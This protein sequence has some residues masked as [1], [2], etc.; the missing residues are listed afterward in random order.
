V[1]KY[2]AFN[3]TRQTLVASE[4]EVAET[5]WSRMKG[6]LGRSAKDFC[7]GKGLWIVPSDGIH[8]IG[9]SFPIDVVYLDSKRRVIRTYHRLA[10]FRIAAVKLR[11]RSIL[12]LPPGALAESRT[13][14]GDLLQF[15]VSEE[16]RGVAC[17][18]NT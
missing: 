13:E 8:T 7:N 11:A 5:A 6:L 12:E 4:L 16:E 9:M 1:T 18:V 14:V 10:P 15:L 2:C 3:C 17:A